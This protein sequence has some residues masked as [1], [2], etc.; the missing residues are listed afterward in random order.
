MKQIY[1]TVRYKIVKYNGGISVDGFDSATHELKSYIV[2]LFEKIQATDTKDKMDFS[3]Y[4]LSSKYENHFY[5][6]MIGNVE[7]DLENFVK[8][9]EAIYSSLEGLSGYLFIS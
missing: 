4:P 5:V 9:F 8:R 7:I 1:Q 3:R 6:D 2:E